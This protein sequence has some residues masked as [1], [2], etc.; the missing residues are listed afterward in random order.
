MSNPTKNRT[1]LG[2][3]HEVRDRLKDFNII[4]GDYNQKLTTM[5]DFIEANVELFVKFQMK[6]LMEKQYKKREDKDQSIDFD[7]LQTSRFDEL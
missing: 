2:I 5:M 1:S 4:G 6:E 3:D 7:K